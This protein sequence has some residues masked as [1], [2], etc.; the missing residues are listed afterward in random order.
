[1]IKEKDGHISATVLEHAAV[2]GKIQPDF[3]E[4]S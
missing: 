4:K 2:K 1:M 3:S